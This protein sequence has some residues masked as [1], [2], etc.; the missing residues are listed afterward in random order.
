MLLLSLN[1]K[2]QDLYIYFFY[3]YFFLTELKMGYQEQS[4]LDYL[5]SHF[6]GEQL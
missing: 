4:S 1:L 5:N 2:I 3:I 6:K